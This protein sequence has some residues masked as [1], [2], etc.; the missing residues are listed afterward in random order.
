MAS[1]TQK[2]KAVHFVSIIGE[3]LIYDVI[4]S[5]VPFIASILVRTLAELE[6]PP[7]AYAP[8]ILFFSVAITATSIRDIVKEQNKGNLVWLFNIFLGTLVIGLLASA[9]F[10]GFY[11]NEAILNAGNGKVRNNITSFSFI[12]AISMLTI[13]L[14]VQILLGLGE[15][16]KR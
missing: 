16:E 6:A 12:I 15:L 5:L 8:E 7:G 10:F 3:F 9:I 13:S 4:L 2:S 1:T 11:Q 14:I